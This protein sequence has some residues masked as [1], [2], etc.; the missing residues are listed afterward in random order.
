VSIQALAGQFPVPDGWSAYAA[1]L[2]DQRPAS[3][4]EDRRSLVRVIGRQDRCQ[5]GT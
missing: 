4:N 1:R 3:F 5:H 2:E